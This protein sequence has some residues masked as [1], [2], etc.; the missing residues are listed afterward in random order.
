MKRQKRTG[1]SKDVETVETRSSS[2]ENVKLLKHI[3]EQ[4]A[5][6]LKYSTRS[7]HMPQ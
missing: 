3:R 1:A 6:A 2:T 5:S 7:Y 4:S